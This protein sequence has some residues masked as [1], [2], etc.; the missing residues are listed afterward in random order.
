MNAL[1]LGIAEE[2]IDTNIAAFS[3]CIKQITRPG[4]IQIRHRSL[5]F[6]ML[7]PANADFYEQHDYERALIWHIRDY[8]VKDILND[9]FHEAGMETLLPKADNYVKFSNESIEKV[10]PYE[11]ILE[12]DRRNAIGFRFTVPP[13]NNE[14]E[15]KRWIK[16]QNAYHKITVNYIIVID[17]KDANATELKHKYDG[18]AYEGIMERIPVRAFFSRFFSDEIYQLYLKKIRIAIKTAYDEVGFKTIPRMTNKYLD[19]FTDKLNKE[20]SEERF[21]DLKYNVIKTDDTAIV[22]RAQRQ[23]SEDDA[24]IIDSRFR[25]KKLHR[26]LTGNTNFAKCFIT[27]EYMASIFGEGGEFEFTSIVAGYL[28]SVEQLLYTLVVKTESEDDLWITA[29]RRNNK[30]IEQ[31]KMRQVERPSKNGKTNYYYE[32]K[33]SP[34]K[35]NFSKSMGSYIWFLYENVNAW[36][37]SEEGRKIIRDYLL[38]YCD[39]DRN[40]HFHRDN[41]TDFKEVEIIQNN[42]KLVLYLVLGGYNF[43][44]KHEMEILGIK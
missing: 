10:F 22:E 5:D 31:G 7:E 38:N 8:L 36:N 16:R 32:V 23:L 25:D 11:I 43:N 26:A 40:E 24:K 13:V 30:M 37:I 15:L 12:K 21:H 41:I 18:D 29:T 35:N 9:L 2:I 3:D 6:P 4:K 27:S 44:E 19:S 17:W 42:T 1:D 14:K 34:D 20:L 28:K 39:E 33:F